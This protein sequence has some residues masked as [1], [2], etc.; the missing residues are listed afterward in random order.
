MDRRIKYVKVIL[1]FRKDFTVNV[2]K[3]YEQKI[4][5]TLQ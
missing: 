1:N 5:I 2:Y 4:G 3:F